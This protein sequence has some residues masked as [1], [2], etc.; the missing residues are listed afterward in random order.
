M[1]Q[2][3]QGIRSDLQTT[4]LFQK[5]LENMDSYLTEQSIHQMETLSSQDDIKAHTEDSQNS[6]APESSISQKAPQEFFEED[7]CLQD[8]REEKQ[9]ERALAKRKPKNVFQLTSIKE[10]KKSKRCRKREVPQMVSHKIGPQRLTMKK[11]VFQRG[12]SSKKRFLGFQERDFLS[13]NEDERLG[14][15]DTKPQYPKT[16]PDARSVL[17]TKRHASATHSAN[18]GVS[19][20]D[21]GGAR[22]HNETIDQILKHNFDPIID[23]LDS[24][25]PD[26]IFQ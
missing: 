20:V 24:Y 10:N 8:I 5:S 22:L 26:L 1:P 6:I 16:V 19:T 9:V 17:K 11:G 23:E 25:L 2:L 18:P 21:D 3:V 15:M 12:K 13:C 4:Y 14:P 7:G